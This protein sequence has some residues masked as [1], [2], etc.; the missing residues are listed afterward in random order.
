MERNR[1]GGGLGL[2]RGGGGNRPLSSLPLWGVLFF[3]FFLFGHLQE[4]TSTIHISSI[5]V[6][7]RP[8]YVRLALWFLHHPAWVKGHT[9]GSRLTPTVHH[10]CPVQLG[11]LWVAYVVQE[12]NEHHSNTRKLAHGSGARVQDHDPRSQP[13]RFSSEEP[14]LERS[15][16]LSER[17]PVPHHL[18]S[19]RARGDLR[20]HVSQCFQRR[21]WRVQLWPRVRLCIPSRPTSRGR[22]ASLVSPLSVS[23]YPVLMGCP[24][25]LA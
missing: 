18:S 12:P 5:I 24:S 20:Q 11:R 9:G 1:G 21:C 7:R 16:T 23:A 13:A 17:Q 10:P 19:T 4:H 25:C 8:V 3:F 15:S 22:W 2:G 14:L 6:A